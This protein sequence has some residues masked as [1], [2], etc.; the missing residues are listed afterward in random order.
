[1]AVW[2]NGSGSKLERRQADRQ[3]RR[4]PLKS[5]KTDSEMAS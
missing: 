1:M 5:P 3:W 4:K 2:R